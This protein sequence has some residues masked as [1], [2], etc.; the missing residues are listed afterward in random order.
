MPLVADSLLTA[1]DLLT[2]ACDL[3]ARLCVA[4]IEA[5]EPHCRRNVNNSTA[6]LTALIDK[7]G[8][9]AAEQLAEE[10]SASHCHQKNIR[11]LAIDRGLLTAEEF[12]ELTSP[13]RITRLGSNCKP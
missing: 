1:I 5:D 12:D 6:L 11:Q 13:E 3:F 4:G 9:A 2:G 8:Y 7:I 10:A